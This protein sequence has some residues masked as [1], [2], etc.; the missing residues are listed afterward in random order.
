MTP[1][2]LKAHYGEDE[3][4][5][6][7]DAQLDQAI[8]RAIGTV[9]RYLP[10]TPDPATPA[11]LAVSKVTLTL[12]RAYAHDEQAFGDDH[13]VVREM[14]EALSWLKMVAQGHIPL[15]TEDTSPRPLPVHGIA[16]SAPEPV[17]TQSLFDR[18]PR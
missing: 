11:G 16:V 6:L 13:P 12:A 15:F 3:F 10:S 1:A 2:D 9:S 17:F 5:H 8:A 14:R 4:A 7:D 18:W